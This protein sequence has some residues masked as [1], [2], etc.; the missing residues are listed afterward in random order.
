MTLEALLRHPALWQGRQQQQQSHRETLSSGYP[1]LDA[2]LPSH[3]WPVG[4]L[5]EIM[6]SCSGIGELSML[7]PALRQLTRQQHWVALI[8]PPHVPY[9]PALI[10]A[11]LDLDRTLVVD[12]DTSGNPKEKQKNDFWATEQLLRS[13]IFSAVILWSGRHSNDR[14]QRRLQLAAEHGKCWAVCYRPEYAAKSASPAGLRMILK[15]QQQ[16][17]YIDIIKNRGGKLHQLS[18]QQKPAATS[19]ISSLQ[20]RQATAMTPTP[21]SPG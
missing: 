16:Q 9:A 17:L 20:H 5:T 2:V 1:Q 14:T 6:T 19:H 15:Q 8:A 4:A 3:G 13:G 12:S 10:E 18:L 21:L 11:G 7:M